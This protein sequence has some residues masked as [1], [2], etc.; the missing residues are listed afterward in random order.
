MKKILL[1]VVCCFLLSCERKTFDYFSQNAPGDSGALFAPGLISDTVKKAWSLAVSPYGDEVFFARGV[2]PHTKIM[3]MKKERNKWSLPDTAIFSKECWATEP[4]FSPD[5]N[6][7]YFSTSKGKTDIYSYSLWR[8]KRIR[9]GWSHPER[10]FEIGG[11]S[12]WEFHPTITSDG[13]LYFC[14][15]DSKN[16]SGSIY[17]SQCAVNKFSEPIRIGNPI[18]TGFSDVNPFVNPEGRYLIF[19]SDRPGGYGGYDR[20]I[21]FRNNDGKW[22]IPKNMGPKFN[23]NDDD[24]DM[25]VSSDGKYIFAYLKGNVFWMPVGDLICQ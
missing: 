17:M 16:Q 1:L 22:T 20:Y 10:L 23:T 19:I 21:S 13:S 15:W 6:Y 14:C 12:I 4:S 25:D 5:G 11:D 18:N 8:I 2:W 3:Y 24:S 9:H 7:L